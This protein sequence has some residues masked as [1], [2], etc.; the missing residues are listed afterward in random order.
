MYRI[1]KM[2][3]VNCFL[4]VAVVGCGRDHIITFDIENSSG[5]DVSTLSLTIT[6]S[7]NSQKLSVG[8]LARNES[9]SVKWDVDGLIETDGGF[10]VEVYFTEEDSLKRGFGYFSNG[11]HYTRHYA[12]TIMDTI[13]I[14]DEI[15]T[16]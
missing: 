8:Q 15:R 14:W 10:E 13:I 12:I 2:I 4:M 6:N 11:Y 1:V 9:R 16:E 7:I 3:F 5:K